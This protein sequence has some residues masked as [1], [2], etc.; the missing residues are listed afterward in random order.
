ELAVGAEGALQL[1]PPL[2][3]HRRRLGEELADQLLEGAGEGAEGDVALEEV[4]LAG[5]EAAA[6]A[7]DRLV[8]LVDQPR[9]ADAGAAG[10]ED[11]LGEA[12]VGAVEGAGERPHVGLAAVEALGDPQGLGDVALTELEGRDLAALAQSLEAERE[13]GGEAERVLIAILGPLA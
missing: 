4:E 5:D 3:D 11:E 7:G 8:D 12:V 6:G 13:V 2:A 1:R 10:D 9:L